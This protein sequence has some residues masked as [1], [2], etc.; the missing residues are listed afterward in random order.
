MGIFIKDKRKPLS[1]HKPGSFGYYREKRRQYT[2]AQEA[3][4]KARRRQ[5][6]LYIGSG[7]M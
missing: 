1:E 3:K 6:D 4:R 2:E 5:D 7:L